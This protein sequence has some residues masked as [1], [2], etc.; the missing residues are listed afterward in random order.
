MK[1]TSTALPSSEQFRANRDA[2][3][4][5]IGGVHAHLVSY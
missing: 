5:L 1:L 2:H 4:A 3:L